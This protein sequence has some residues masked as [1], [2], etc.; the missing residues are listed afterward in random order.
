MTLRDDEYLTIA[1]VA[2]GLYKEKGSRFLAFVYN[3]TTADEAKEIIEAKD[4]EFHDARHCCYAWKLIG[5]DDYKSSDDGEPSGTAGKPILGQIVSAGLSNV[6]IVVVR[7]FGGIKL[8]TGGLIVAYKTAAADA[9]ASA[10]T[11][12][13]TIRSQV[14]VRFPYMAMNGVMRVVKDCSPNIVEQSFDNDCTMVLDI[15][16]GAVDSLVQRLESLW[17]EGVE[18]VT[19]ERNDV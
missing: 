10:T 15:R 7:Y 17:L 16:K 5:K 2:E 6:L 14:T 12:V 19:F 11:E 3:V 9:I 1:D 4:K 18:G 13:R 8:G